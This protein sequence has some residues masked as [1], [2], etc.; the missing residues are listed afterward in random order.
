MVVGEVYS[1]RKYMSA[2]TSMGETCI[3][4]IYDKGLYLRLQASP[5]AL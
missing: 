1:A 3:E 2:P 4:A 5:S